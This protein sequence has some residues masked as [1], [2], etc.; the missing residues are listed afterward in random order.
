MTSNVGLNQKLPWFGTFRGRIDRLVNPD[1]NQGL[2]AFLAAHPGVDKVAFTGSTE[3]GKGIQR[4]L[5]GSGKRL[6]LELGGKAANIIFDDAALDQAVEGIVN[7]IFFN[8]GHVCCA[9]SRLL[10][11]EGVSERLI[12]KLR[13]RMRHC[14]ASG[15]A[16]STSASR[17]TWMSGGATDM[18]CRAVRERLAAELARCTGRAADAAR[19]P[20][21]ERR[22]SDDLE[23]HPARHRRTAPIH[24]LSVPGRRR[25][26][27]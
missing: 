12:A 19:A 6:T 16:G 23:E 5:A 22:R 13:A 9:G 4:E 15:S 11:Q 14:Q 27:G 20:L 2:P 21:R 18:A 7:G 24:G 26:A 8:Q 3:V 17:Q 10:V 1:L 25:A